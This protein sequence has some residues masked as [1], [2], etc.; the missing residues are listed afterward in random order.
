MNILPFD[1]GNNKFDLRPFIT[2]TENTAAQLEKEN[3]LRI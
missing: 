1:C 3:S 2:N